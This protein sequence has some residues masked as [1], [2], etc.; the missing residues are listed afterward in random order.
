MR[1]SLFRCCSSEAD[2]AQENG[3]RAMAGGRGQAVTATASQASGS[4]AHGAGSPAVNGSH[5]YTRHSLV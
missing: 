2:G 1:V 4:R 5:R 3:A